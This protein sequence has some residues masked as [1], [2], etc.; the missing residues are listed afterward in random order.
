M[1]FWLANYVFALSGGRLDR[2]TEYFILWD[3]PLSRGWQYYHA[4]IVANG[5][6]TTRMGFAQL[7][8]LKHME[9][10]DDAEHS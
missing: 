4:A 3:L 7:E 8:L 1:P 2:N 10:I 9:D 5:M 6:Q